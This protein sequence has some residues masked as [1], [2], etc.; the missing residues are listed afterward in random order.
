MGLP[1]RKS[2]LAN[3]HVT[4]HCQG[5]RRWRASTRNSSIGF[6]V[7]GGEFGARIMLADM[8]SWGNVDM[9]DV[10]LTGANEVPHWDLTKGFERIELH[11]AAESTQQCLTYLETPTLYQQEEPSSSWMWLV[12]K[13]AMVCATVIKLSC[14]GSTLKSCSNDHDHWNDVFQFNLSRQ[15]QC[16]L[17]C[18]KQHANC[19]MSNRAFFIMFQWS[20]CLSSRG[21]VPSSFRWSF[22]LLRAR[23]PHTIL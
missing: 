22:Y 16:Q 14:M 8:C 20:F 7:N 9:V 1:N 12:T 15:S 11:W 4:A 13:L 18:T 5:K 2:S 3:L 10:Y 6:N 17:S 21:N 19:R 23:T